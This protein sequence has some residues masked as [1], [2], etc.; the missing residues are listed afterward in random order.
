M[1]TR[2]AAQWLSTQL[3]DVRPAD[4]HP[5]AQWTDHPR[6]VLRAADDVAAPRIPRIIVPAVCHLRTVV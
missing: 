4:S 2:S 1:S 5:P 3:A 6:S